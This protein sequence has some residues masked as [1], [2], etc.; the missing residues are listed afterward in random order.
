MRFTDWSLRLCAARAMENGCY[1]IANN[2][3]FNCP[4]EPEEQAGY[5]FVIDPYG[6]VIHCDAPPGDTEKMALITVDTEVVRERRE[7]EGEHFNLW[8]R[9]PSA[10][11]RLVEPRNDGT[12]GS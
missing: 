7:M 2:N 11:H 4:I 9:T 12:L 3:I 8:S 5:T 10:Y 1:L 6:R